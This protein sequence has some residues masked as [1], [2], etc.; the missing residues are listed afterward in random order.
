MGSRYISRFVAGSDE[1]AGLLPVRLRLSGHN[2]LIPCGFQRVEAYWQSSLPG[3]ASGCQLPFDECAGS[4]GIAVPKQIVM[5][6]RNG[7]VN[8]ALRFR[9]PPG[10]HTIVFKAVHKD[11]WPA[12]TANIT[13]N[14]RACEPGEREVGADAVDTAANCI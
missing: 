11:N 6:L 12:V 5:S 10:N 1:D 8:F 14:V 7:T 3:T 9:Q 2:G 4:A 13:V